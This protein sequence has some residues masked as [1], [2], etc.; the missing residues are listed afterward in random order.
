MSRIKEMSTEQGKGEPS[1]GEHLRQAAS[2]VGEQIRDRAG[3]YYEE[4]RQQAREWEQHLENYVVDRP[5]K[6]LLVAA[7][8]GLAVGFLIRRS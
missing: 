6:S 1:A 4:G 3:H 8:I 7:G 2:Q 5:I